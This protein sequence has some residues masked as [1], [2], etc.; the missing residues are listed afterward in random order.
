MAIILNVIAVIIVSAVAVLVLIHREHAASELQAA[1]GQRGGQRQGQRL[2]AA[3]KA[4]GARSA[5]R[6][7][8]ARE[9]RWRRRGGREQT[10]ESYRQSREGRLQSHKGYQR[11][12][13][14]NWQS[15]RGRQPRRLSRLKS[16]E[17]CELK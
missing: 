9:G 4:H 13:A 12:Y 2:V 16:C 7:L 17:E 15:L 14:G 8:R 11:G 6:H 10:S 5:R 1:V 3:A